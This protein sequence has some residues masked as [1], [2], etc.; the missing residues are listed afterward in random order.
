MYKLFHSGK[1]FLFD[2]PVFYKSP[3]AARD[4]DF[5][6]NKK[7]KKNSVKLPMG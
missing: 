1:I 6:E 5:N 7:I 3:E 4:K 2:L